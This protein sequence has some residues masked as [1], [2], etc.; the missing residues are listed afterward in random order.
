VRPGKQDAPAATPAPSKPAETR[1]QDAPRSRGSDQKDN[2]KSS[3]NATRR[4]PADGR[5]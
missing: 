1:R 3:E 2:A 5:K 4:A